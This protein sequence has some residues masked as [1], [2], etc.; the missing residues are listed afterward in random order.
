MI[1]FTSICCIMSGA[2]VFMHICMCNL[3]I[4]KPNVTFDEENM[5]DTFLRTIFAQLSL[6]QLLW[7]CQTAKGNI[8]MTFFHVSRYGGTM[9]TT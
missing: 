1:L 7:A 9:S 5:G 2:S 6:S 4:P 3:V 8:A